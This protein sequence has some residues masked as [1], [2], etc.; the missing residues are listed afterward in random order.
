MRPPLRPAPDGNIPVFLSVRA[1]PS[2]RTN[3]V[4]AY[5]EPL[6]GG[7]RVLRLSSVTDADG[8]VTTLSYTNSDPSLITGVSDPFAAA[9][10]CDMKASA[11]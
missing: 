8:R 2:G 5:D 3:V 4:F 7:T 6:V 10:S 1:D 9:P 11:G